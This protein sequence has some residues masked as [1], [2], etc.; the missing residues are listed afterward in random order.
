LLHYLISLVQNPPP[1]KFVC[2]VVGIVQP[3]VHLEYCAEQG[4]LSHLQPQQLGMGHAQQAAVQLNLARPPA[5][6]LC[7]EGLAV[8]AAGLRFCGMDVGVF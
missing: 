4:A 6:S 8:L 1:A 5:L 3:L 7:K 2:S